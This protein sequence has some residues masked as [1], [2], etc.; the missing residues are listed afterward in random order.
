[1]KKLLSIVW[2]G[3]VI[4]CADASAF[5]GQPTCPLLADAAEATSSSKRQDILQ[6][7]VALPLYSQPESRIGRLV[8][9]LT[10]KAPIRAE[11][12]FDIGMAR[13]SMDDIG[14]YYYRT[15]KLAQC[16]ANLVKRANLGD[17]QKTAIIERIYNDWNTGQPG[18]RY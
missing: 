12:Y 7:L 15:K 10:R 8:I 5:G 16:V 18:F 4:H 1:M 6:K 9:W 13:I 3:I 14:A 2:L 17:E 11:K